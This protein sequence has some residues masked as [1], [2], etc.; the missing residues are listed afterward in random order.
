M[1]V[2]GC[3]LDPVS[4]P[5]RPDP[6]SEPTLVPTLPAVAKP[7]FTVEL[8]TV[9]E[10]LA[11][12]GRV[13]P[14]EETE[15]RF[16]VPGVIGDVLVA[17]GDDVAEGDVIAKL[18]QDLLE[19]QL[20][21]AQLELAEAQASYDEAAN[22]VLSERRL[23]EIDLERAQLLLEHA[24]T[25]AGSNPSTQQQ[26]DIQLLQLDVEEAQLA[27]DLFGTAEVPLENNI[28]ALEEAVAE[29][30]A[31]L[32]TA[33]LLAPQS[34]QILALTVDIGDQVRERQ[35]VGLIGDPSSLEIKA[36]VND[37]ILTQLEEGMEVTLSSNRLDAPQTGIVRQLP[38]PYGSGD[39]DDPSVHIALDNIDQTGLGIR[40][41][42]SIDIVL[43]ERV[44]VP[45]LHP[46]AIREFSGRRFVLVEMPDGE[47]QRIDI[48]MGLTTDEQVEITSGLAG[49]EIVIGP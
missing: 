5:R 39:L 10:N 13:A 45:W 37:R 33:E 22:L 48:Q 16:E 41:P 21:E 29:I 18:D 20:V 31:Q 6:V 28:A 36:D 44:D 26:L 17:V 30:E 7:R 23:L 38:A 43:E 47:Q 3:V 32:A 8:G 25:V 35:V 15:I 4:E 12:S 27:L 49:G 14:V 9:Q 2:T 11:F 34:G 19:E 24:Q 46:A 40:M 1:V 42:I